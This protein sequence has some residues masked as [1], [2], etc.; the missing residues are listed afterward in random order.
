[1]KKEESEDWYTMK[2]EHKATA[3]PEVFAMARGLCVNSE[4]LR[5]GT[6]CLSNRRQVPRD[7]F[8]V[9]VLAVGPAVPSH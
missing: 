2:L 3:H 1:M 8:V 4:V 7:A 6:V 9:I 5:Q